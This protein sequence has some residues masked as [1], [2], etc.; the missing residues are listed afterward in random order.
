[1]YQIKRKQLVKTD[2][3]TCWNFFSAPANLETITPDGFSMRVL[4][5]QPTVMYEGLIIYYR[6]AP[7]LHIPLGWITEITHVKHHQFFVDEQRK[8][9]YRLWHHEHHFEEVEGGVMMTDIVSYALP[10]GIFGK[11]AHWLFV[12]R[13]LEGIFEYRHK[14]VEEL[15]NS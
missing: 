5:E 9:P 10:F 14:K 8:G 13:Q 12:R 15:F 4:T 6:M 2:M 1:M 11:F 7:V 3:E